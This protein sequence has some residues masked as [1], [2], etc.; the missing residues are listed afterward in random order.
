MVM[1]NGTEEQGPNPIVFRLVWGL[2]AVVAVGSIWVVW[3]AYQKQTQ[4]NQA[5]RYRLSGVWVRR[6]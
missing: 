6:T 5:G 2:V 1:E 3:D 4:R